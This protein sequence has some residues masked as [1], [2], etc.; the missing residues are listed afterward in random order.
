MSSAICFNLDQSKILS[1]GNEL[2]GKFHLN[3]LSG[4]PEPFADSIEQDQTVKNLHS[5]LASTLYNIE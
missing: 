4:T 5:N 1:P 2:E 3:L